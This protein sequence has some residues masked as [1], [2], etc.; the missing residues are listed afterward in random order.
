MSFPRLK[1][2]VFCLA[3]VAV[4]VGTN[5]AIAQDTDVVDEIVAVVSDQIILKS[6]VDAM[7]ANIMRQQPRMQYTEDIWMDALDQMINQHVMSVVA[8]R[9]TNIV[10]SDDQVTQALDRRIDQMIDQVGSQARLEELYGKSLVRIRSELREDFRDQLLAEQ[11]QQTKMRDIRITPSEV[12]EWF[13][14]FPTDSLPTLPEIVRVSHIVRFPAVTEDAKEEA[15]QIITA[16]RD[17]VVNT[18]ATLEEMAR[19]FSDDPGSATAGGRIEDTNLSDLVPEFAAV[20]S[21]IPIGEISQIF[22]S[23]FGYHILRVNERRGE[24]VD[25]NHILIQIDDSRI[26]PSETISFLETV[27][28]SIITHDVPFALMA[29]RHSEEQQ[30]AQL[31]GRVLDPQTGERDLV[32]ASLGPLWQEVLDTL[33]VG[34]ISHPARVELESDRQ[35]YHIVLQQRRMPEHQVDLDTD[36]ERIEQYALQEKRARIMQEWISRLREDVYVDLRGKAQRLS[37]AKR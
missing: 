21:R 31:G 33:E 18:D 35:A 5:T 34:E 36:Y 11:I 32:L 26:D 15:R 17:S 1:Y 8:K 27:R 29:K 9:D 24:I 28:D 3:V 12:K 37:L 20:A 16:I 2:L 6:E 13:N 7:V 25:F 4:L 19:R 23:P 14:Q 22:E 10:V 30:S